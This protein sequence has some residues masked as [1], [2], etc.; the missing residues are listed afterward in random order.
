MQKFGGIARSSGVPGEAREERRGSWRDRVP[1][2]VCEFSWAG[3][4][5]SIDW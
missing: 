1:L 4:G 3:A 2:R 5:S